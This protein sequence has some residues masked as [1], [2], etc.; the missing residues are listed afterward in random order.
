METIGV[1][2]H[3]D[4]LIPGFDVGVPVDHGVT[5]DLPDGDAW[6]RMGVLYNE[7]ARVVSEHAPPLLVVSGPA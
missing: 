6:K 5:V 1:P 2:Y 3:Q 4:E 7:V